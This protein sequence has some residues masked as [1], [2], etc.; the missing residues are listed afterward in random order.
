MRTEHPSETPSR[1]QDVSALFAQWRTSRK[2]RTNIPEQLW[3]AAVDLSPFYATHRIARA[4]RLNY[5]ELKD[6]IKKSI[7]EE[8][9]AQFIE[10]DMRQAWL[11]TPCVLELR[12][13]DGFELKIHNFDR[14]Q[15]QLACIVSCFVGKR[16]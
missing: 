8:R 2:P 16:R 4:L 11:T 9:A 5:S 12:S 10:I 3:Q 14:I 6:R 1:L 13:P 15:S 7:P